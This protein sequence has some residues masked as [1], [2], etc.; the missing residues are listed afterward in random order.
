MAEGGGRGGLVLGQLGLGASEVHLQLAK[1]VL[2]DGNDADAAVNWVAEAHLGLVGQ[3]VDRILSLVGGKLVEKLGDVARPEDLV[4][5]CEFLRLIGREVG[6]EDAVGLAL[7]PQELA[8]GAGGARRRRR[9][10]RRPRR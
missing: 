2:E 8:S 7:A 4:H 9:R 5:V 3:G 1:L 6:R 10:H